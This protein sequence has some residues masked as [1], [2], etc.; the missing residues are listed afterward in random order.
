M[1]TS[2]LIIGMTMLSK[3]CIFAL[4]LV[5]AVLGVN[6]FLLHKEKDSYIYVLYYIAGVYFITL[7]MITGVTAPWNIH[8][9]HNYEFIPFV[10]FEWRYF[11]L[12]IL[13]FL[14]LGCFVHLIL[15]KKKHFSFQV[16]LICIS[17][18]VGIELIQF[19]FTGRLAD[20]D[21]LIANSVG[22][23]VGYV[24]FYLVY[25]I[26]K[27]HQTYPTGIGSFS[28]LTS[29]L[30]FLFGVPYRYGLCLGDMIFVKWGLPIW[31]GNLNGHLSFDGIHFSLPAY[32]MI[33][34]LAFFI[35]KK[36]PKQFG[37]KLGKIISFI[38]IIYFVILIIYN[39]ISY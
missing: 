13:L 35:A 4:F 17:I 39:I 6:K 5:I 1:I 7:L 21:D 18:S 33:Q 28:I 34:V 16:I 36:N 12:N 30:G 3:S 22:C 32:L 26:V 20:I 29:L 31:S 8:N 24:F 10:N 14:P 38:G 11:L 15:E 23:I 25:G 9:A 27:T 19:F 2:K 37:S